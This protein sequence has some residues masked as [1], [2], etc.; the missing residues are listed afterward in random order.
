MKNI[1]PIIAIFCTA[2]ASCQNKSSKTTSTTDSTQTSAVDTAIS[3]TECFTYIKNRDTAVVKLTTTGKSISGDLNYKL[4]E[5]DR[6]SGTISGIVKGDTLFAEYTFQSEGKSSI[7]EVAFLKKG[8]ALI[9]G[10]GEVEETGGKVKFKHPASLKF[11][12]AMVFG[13]T[14]CN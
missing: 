12:D 4:F 13:K 6:N 9:E 10:F 14:T 3:T 11:S 7:R 2:L 8:D 1:I 5:K